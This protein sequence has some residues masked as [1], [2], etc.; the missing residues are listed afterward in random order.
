MLNSPYISE[1]IER[2]RIDEI[3]VAMKQAEL[4][5]MQTFDQSLYALYNKGVITLDQ[6]LSSADSK[7]DLRLRVRL[8]AP[9]QFENSC[10]LEIKEVQE[11]G[12][13][14]LR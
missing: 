14:D 3:K 6:A 5:G 8:E 13:I 9:E 7:N 10:D 11:N 4:I 1:L 12:T 2:G